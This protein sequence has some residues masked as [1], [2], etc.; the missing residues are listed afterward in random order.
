MTLARKI[1][2][3]IA[4]RQAFAPSVLVGAWYSNNTH[5]ESRRAVVAAVMGM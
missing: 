4:K 3:Y 2:A 5:S 1:L